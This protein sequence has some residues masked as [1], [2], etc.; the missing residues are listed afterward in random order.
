[1]RAAAVSRVGGADGWKRRKANESNPAGI[2]LPGLVLNIAASR[3]ASDFGFRVQAGSRWSG[4][5][6]G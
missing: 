4:S 5:L 2:A 3:F 6:A 1:M